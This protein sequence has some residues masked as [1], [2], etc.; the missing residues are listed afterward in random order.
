M[1]V[2]LER[3]AF[4]RLSLMEGNTTSAPGMMHSRTTELARPGVGWKVLVGV[5]TGVIVE[6]AVQFQVGLSVFIKLLSSFSMI[7]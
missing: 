2:S 5:R 7:A 6:K 3:S 1:E 4:F